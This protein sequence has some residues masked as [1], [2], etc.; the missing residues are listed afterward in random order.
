METKLEI[1]IYDFYKIMSENHI[2]LIYQGLFDQEMIKSVLS[3]TEKKLTQENVDESIRKKLFNIMVEGLQNICKHQ[4]TIP[5]INENPMLIISQSEEHF[6]I[7]TGNLLTN[8]KIGIIEPKINQVNNLD[9]D[10]LKELYKKAR[11]NSTIS[12]VGG[13]GLGFID[14]ARKSGNK[15]DFKFY[16]ITNEISFFVQ[17]VKLNK[18]NPSN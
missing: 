5:E 4:I 13:A 3:M 14:I 15:I 2:L 8:N 16:P 18:N 11:L 7:I 12:E 17:S 10:E 1:E 9:K 6:F